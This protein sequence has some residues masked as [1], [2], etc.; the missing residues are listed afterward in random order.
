MDR[1]QALEVLMHAQLMELLAKDLLGID[2]DTLIRQYENKPEFKMEQLPAEPAVFR[3]DTE[4]LA[5][6]HNHG[7]TPL[8]ISQMSYAEKSRIGV[9]LAR[10]LGKAVVWS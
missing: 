5:Y 9:E 6:M 8:Q 10:K 3:P 1:Y 4:K 7:Y 2:E